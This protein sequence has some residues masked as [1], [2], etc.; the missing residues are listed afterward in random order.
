MATIR[1]T[2]KT[3]QVVTL[4]GTTGADYFFGG[5]GKDTFVGNG[6]ADYFKAGYGSA[7]VDYSWAPSGITVNLSKDFA[8]QTGGGGLNTLIGITGII[9]T[10]YDDN[11]W[12]NY[13]ND[14]LKGNGGNDTINGSDG[15]DQIEGGDGNDTLGG[16]N[17]EDS[18]FGGTG[19]DVLRG[20]RDGDLLDGGSGDDLIFGGGLNDRL[21]GGYGNDTLA[22]GQGID[23]VDG[24]DGFDIALF[25]DALKGVTI[26]RRD[27]S[28]RSNTND[29]GGDV[30]VHIEAY[31]LTYYSDRFIAYGETVTVWGMEGD[32][33]LTGSG[34]ADKLYGG[35]GNDRLNGGGHN[36]ILDG[37]DGNDILDGG[38]EAYDIFY[39]GKGNDTFV[40][41][42]GSSQSR[43]PDEIMD[44]NKGDKIDLSRMDPVPGGAD[45][46]LI[47]T[48]GGSVTAAAQVGFQRVDFD[49]LR[50]FADTNGDK[51][52]DFFLLVHT[53]GTLTASDFVL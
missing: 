25:S 6:G 9:G 15:N 18:L 11:I 43:Y 32:D 47:F 48:S 10:R 16:G 23:I 45:N 26:D 5:S 1:S 46:A 17:G 7:T 13:H 35:V 41:T 42:P 21:Y 24:G 39:G 20:E 4:V 19:A 30:F 28:G 3:G 36:D 53:S 2:S 37:G 50:V 29:A 34:G 40:F 51:I 31:Q 8:Q 49:T 14:I 52:A 33:D 22:G 44:W 27:T 12:G 38:Y